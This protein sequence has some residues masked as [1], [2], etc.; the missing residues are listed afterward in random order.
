M[1]NNPIKITMIKDGPLMV[2]GTCK[3]EKQSG[4]P[5]K[6]GEKLFLC[7]CGESKKKPFCDGS[8]KAAGFEG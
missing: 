3:V 8:H 4:E 1:R 7:R 6:E 5:V 2:E